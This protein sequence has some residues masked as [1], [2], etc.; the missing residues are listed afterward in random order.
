MQ[1]PVA[2]LIL[3]LIGLLLARY[4]TPKSAQSMSAGKERALTILLALI[5]IVVIAG[6]FPFFGNG[7]PMGV[8]MATAWGI[9]LGTSGILV[10]DLIGS[11]VMAALRAGLNL[12]PDDA[13]G[14]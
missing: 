14:R 13:S 5:L 1:I 2:A 7:E 10:V 3:S 4:I 12:P 11:R 9:G 6:E 8:G